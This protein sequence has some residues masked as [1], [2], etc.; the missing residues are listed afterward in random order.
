MLNQ[1]NGSQK[2]EKLRPQDGEKLVVNPRSGDCCN[3]TD[4]HLKELVDLKKKRNI[5]MINKS[6]VYQSV[7]WLIFTEC[8][9]N[10]P[11]LFHTLSHL[12]FPAS[13]RGIFI[14]YILHMRTLRPE[15]L[16]NLSKVTQ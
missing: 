16:K 1:P 12:I 8:L 2:K 6:G 5:K 10:M 15:K 7:M 11:F 14:I 13:L 3:I 4:V 9:C